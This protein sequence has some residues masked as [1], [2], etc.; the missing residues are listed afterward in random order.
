M[1]LELA[2]HGV[3][4]VAAGGADSCQGTTG[5]DETDARDADGC[6]DAI[7]LMKPP[8][9]AL[10]RVK[11]PLELMKPPLGALLR[12]RAVG[13][14][15]VSWLARPT[16]LGSRSRLMVLYRVTVV[17]CFQKRSARKGKIIIYCSYLLFFIDF[18]PP[19]YPLW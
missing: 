5:V 1:G 4:K 10:L 18:V 3:A 15:A 11:G 2:T 19:M 13:G 12:V 7:E 16:R 9:G 6:Q 17:P 14:P 8:L